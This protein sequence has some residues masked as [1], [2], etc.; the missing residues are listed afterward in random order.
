MEDL[1]YLEHCF[2]TNDELTSLLLYPESNYISAYTFNQTK[3]RGQY[4][5]SWDS[6][7]GKNLAYS[8]AVNCAAVKV[9]DF[10]F[11]YYTAACV[12]DFLANLTDKNVKIKWPNDLLL[13][14]KKFA[15]ILIQARP[16]KNYM[17]VGIGLNVSGDVRSFP[18]ELRDTATTL[19][20]PLEKKECLLTQFL[21]ELIDWLNV[22]EGAILSYLRQHDYLLG[23]DVITPDGKGKACGISERGLLIVERGGVRSQHQA[24]EVQLA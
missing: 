14:G 10:L 1:F 13:E 4:G 12:R 18:V 21:A 2:S 5:N 20:L 22:P 11:N 9:S 8:L 17:V 6:D 19:A 23:K 16:Q 15:G 3:G 24:G 7:E